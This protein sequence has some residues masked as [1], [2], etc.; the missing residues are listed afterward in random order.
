MKEELDKSDEQSFPPPPPSIELK[1]TI[2]CNW[3]RDT[4]PEC[5]QESGCAVCGQLV[6]LKNMSLLSKTKVNLKILTRENMGI[7][8][9]ER[10]RCSDP[11]E[12]IKGPVLDDTCKWICKQCVLSLNKGKT[13]KYALANGLWMGRIPAQLQNLTFAEQLLIARVRHNKCIVR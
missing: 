10:Y 1:E 2:I 11:I 8:R 12:D 5:F 7:T 3:C 9:C 4:S 13:P 6:A